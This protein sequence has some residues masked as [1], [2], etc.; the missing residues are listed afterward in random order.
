MNESK[1]TEQCPQVN[2]MQ[3]MLWMLICHNYDTDWDEL[4]PLYATSQEDAEN[5]A[6]RWISQT[7][8][9]LARIELRPYPRG[10]TLSREEL[11]GRI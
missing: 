6:Q 9:P 4:I 7:K 5:Q 1:V 3:K 10:F 11:P 8:R 2:N